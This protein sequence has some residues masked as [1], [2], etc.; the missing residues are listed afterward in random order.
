MDDEIGVTSAAHD[1]HRR[2]DDVGAGRMDSLD[3]EMYSEAEDPHDEED[4]EDDAVEDMDAGP[5][6]MD[7]VG[8]I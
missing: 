5:N 8:D 6:G 4:E 2:T 7:F 3:D 1:S